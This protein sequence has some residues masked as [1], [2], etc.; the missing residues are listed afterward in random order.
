MDGFMK[1]FTF[2]L[3][4]LERTRELLIRLMP[5]NMG[6]IC[7]QHCKNLRKCPTSRQSLLKNWPLISCIIVNCVFQL[8]DMAYAEIFPLWAAN[9]KKYGG[10]DYSSADIGKVLTI[11]ST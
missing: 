7:Q 5:T 10:L 8:R 3:K 6:L 4:M 1:H 11:S 2:I 9:H